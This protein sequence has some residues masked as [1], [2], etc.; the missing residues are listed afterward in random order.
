VHNSFDI[1]S[2]CYAE[3]HSVLFGI[4]GSVASTDTQ[5]GEEKK[6]AS[7][8]NLSGCQE[9]LTETLP[10]Y[11]FLLITRT[12]LSHGTLLENVQ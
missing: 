10:T 6:Y 2:Y 3:S 9:I 4:S 12:L 11:H 5:L 8:E 7:I 1:S